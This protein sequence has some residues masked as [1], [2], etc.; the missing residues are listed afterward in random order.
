MA[1][2]LNEARADRDRMADELKATES[3]RTSLA[4]KLEDAT[5]GLEQ[6]RAATDR[7][8][9]LAREIVDVYTPALGSDATAAPEVE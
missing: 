1:F 3:Q 6:L 7:A 5:G 2:L 8:L 9:S 4:E